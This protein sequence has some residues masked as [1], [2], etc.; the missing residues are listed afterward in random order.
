MIAF[1]PD[2]LA[3]VEAARDWYEEKRAGLGAALVDEVSHALARI[4]EAPQSFVRDPAGRAARRAWL[5]R[6]PY[7]LI[8]TVLDD[9][10]ILIVAMAHAKRRQGYWRHRERD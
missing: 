3:E 6:F 1:H 7:S 5:G 4:E 8:F 2:A 10:R 9:H